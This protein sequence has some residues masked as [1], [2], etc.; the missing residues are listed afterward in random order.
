MFRSSGLAALILAVC[1]GCGGGSGSVSGISSPVSSVGVYEGPWWGTLTSTNTGATVTAR[2]LVLGTGEMRFVASNALQASG[3]LS[4]SGS[5]IT[6]S[7]TMYAP[8]GTTF[9][10]SGLSTAPFTLSGT[11]GSNVSGPTI[12]GTYSGGGD[13]GTFSFSYDLSALYTTPVVMAS[14]AGAYASVATSDGSYLTGRLAADGSLTGSD[15]YGTLSGSL[16]VITPAKN[17]FR[18]TAT[19]TPTGQAAQTFTG[20]AFFESA[21][22]P[23]HLYVQATSATGQFAVDLQ[24]TGP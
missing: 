2:A 23:I 10:S 14:D 21:A 5:A 24:R 19:Y 1:V 12:T 16:T 15:A 11:G 9:I 22:S 3:T 13:A 7:G 18:V 17:A 8:T 20:L 6:G 4:V